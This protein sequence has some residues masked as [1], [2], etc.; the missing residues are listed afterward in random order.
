MSVID[1]HHHVWDLGVHDQPWITGTVDA[2]GPRRR[3]MFGSDWPVCT[4]AARY[5][6]VLARRHYGVGGAHTRVT[7]PLSPAARGG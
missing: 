1:A 6:D 5:G 4:L 7:W 3:L 2:F